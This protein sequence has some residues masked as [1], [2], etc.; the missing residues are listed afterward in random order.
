MYSPFTFNDKQSYNMILASS[1]EQVAQGTHLQSTT[2]N[3]SHVSSPPEIVRENHVPLKS[4]LSSHPMLAS[5]QHHSPSVPCHLINSGHAS[6]YHFPS[7]NRRSCFRNKQSPNRKLRLNRF[8]RT[9]RADTPAKAT[10][11]R[12]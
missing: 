6:A 9:H 2:I 12:L 4:F 10:S 7:A 1:L 5:M 11:R 3:N 8:L